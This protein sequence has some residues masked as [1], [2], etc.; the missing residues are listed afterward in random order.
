MSTLNDYI[1]LLW[2]QVGKGIYVYGGNGEDLSS[3]T[4]DQRLSYMKK[5]ETETKNSETGKIN[6]TKEQNIARDEA[7]YQKRLAAGVNP[8]LAFD[9][10]GLMYWAGKKTGYIPRDL[11]A[12]TLYSKCKQI[13]KSEIRRGDYCFKHNG[14]KA[15]HVGMYVGD[16]IIIECQGRDVGV[17][18]NKLSRT[19]VFN[20]FGRYPAFENEEDPEPYKPD[21]SIPDPKPPLP[22]DPSKKYVV[23]NGKMRYVT[24]EDG[25]K[26]KKPDKR[27]NIR[28]GNGTMYPVIKVAYSEEKYLFI[29][30]G[31]A[32]P[33][34]YKIYYKGQEAWITS[35][36]RYTH[37][38]PCN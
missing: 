3:M 24:N 7:L 2:T 8:I 32:S 19:S 35:N 36:D 16:D 10:S 23:I 12:N 34:W 25:K 5:R 33:Y 22:F 1:D 28:S 30:Q 14:K 9:C 15:T 29:E 26:V 37:I 4:D 21:P 20:A 11:S 18:T 27:V 6:Y 31:D 17:V 38:E 13:S